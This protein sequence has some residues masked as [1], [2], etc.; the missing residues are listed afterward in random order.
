MIALQNMLIDQWYK[1]RIWGWL[2]WPFAKLFVWVVKLRKL[3]YDKKIFSTYRAPVPVIVVGNITVGGTGKTPLVILLAELLQKNNLKPGIVL[4]G[5]KS[6]SSMPI[7]VKP[8]TDPILVGD[9]AVLLAKRS[10]C[11]VVVAKKRALGVKKL[12]DEY[13]VNIVLTDDGL[14]HYALERD[15]EIAV[16]DGTR[17][18]GNGYTLPMG[19]LRELPVRLDAVD[20]TIVNGTD[21][22]FKIAKVY[23]LLNPQKEILL[24]NLAGHMV[25]A[26]AGIGT[27]EKFFNQLRNLG[28]KVIP[29]SFPDHHTFKVA[30]INFSDRLPVLMTE[31]DAVKCRYFANDEHWVV[32]VTAELSTTHV[33]RFNQLVQ[34][35]IHGR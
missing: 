1:P 18:F 13:K 6:N 14:Q 12:L 26:V 21:M 9:E 5:Y 29:H 34:G 31:K 15:I 24:S 28:I 4:R 16:I 22:K 25:H 17:G 23:S 27:P 7:I 10:K 20:M 2:L 11:P 3:C 32:T 35:V 30:D 19:P 33:E 8:N